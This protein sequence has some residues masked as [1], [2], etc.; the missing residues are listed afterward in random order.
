[1]LNVHIGVLA[2]IAQQKTGT[3]RP[4]LPLDSEKYRPLWLRRFKLLRMNQPA[5]TVLEDLTIFL[6][7]VANII[8]IRE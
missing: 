7:I 3:A 4:P 8:D 6:V 2:F 1:V 5:L